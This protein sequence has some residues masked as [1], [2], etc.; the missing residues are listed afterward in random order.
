MQ[1]LSIRQSED[2]SEE[3]NTVEDSS[4]EIVDTKLTDTTDSGIIPVKKIL[5]LLLRPPRPGGKTC[6]R[7]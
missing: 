3:K 1:S 6:K 5:L 7:N 4:N 2:A